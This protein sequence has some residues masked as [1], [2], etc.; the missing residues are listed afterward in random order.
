MA[1]HWERGWCRLSCNEPLE[2]AVDVL[3]LKPDACSF[4]RG[5]GNRVAGGKRQLQGLVEQGLDIRG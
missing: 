4:R 2:S 5:N 1:P 3:R